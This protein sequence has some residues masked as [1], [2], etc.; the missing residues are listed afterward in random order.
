[1]T[2][3]ER[4]NTIGPDLR[5]ECSCGCGKYTHS[6]DNR[7]RKRSYIQGHNKNQLDH[8]M[9]NTPE[10]KIWGYMKKRCYNKNA[11]NYKYYGG[12]GIEVC[13]RWLNSFINFYRDMGDRPSLLHTID[14]VDVNGDYGP[15]NCRWATRKEQANN[16]R[17]PV[18]KVLC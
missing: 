10:Y 18:R 4:L 5:I 7:G 11:H 14:R 12:R 1:M 2:L 15:D 8:G 9:T 3:R 17:M 6:M 16:R 13:D